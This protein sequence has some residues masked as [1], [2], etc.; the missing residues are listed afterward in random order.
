MDCIYIVR[1]PQIS[2]T[3]KYFKPFIQIIKQYCIPETIFLSVQGAEKSKVIPHHKIEKL[4]MEN[5]L[6]YVFLRPGYFMQ[7]L[8]TTLLSDIKQKRQII[9]PAGKAKFNW[10]DVENI[11]E[12]SAIVINKFQEF[13]NN[14]FEVTGNEIENFY[15][16]ETLMNK[17]LSNRVTYAATNPFKFYALKKKE[18]MNKSMILVMIMLHFLPRFQKLPRISNFYTSITN[19]K[20]T[21]L[22]NFIEREKDKFN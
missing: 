20:P 11:G 13:K 18:G 14:A 6:N 5:Q 4:I 9:L 1:P 8:T 22:L 17:V 19:K 21:G 7:N 16:V 12:V 15:T 2:D 3:D 10:I